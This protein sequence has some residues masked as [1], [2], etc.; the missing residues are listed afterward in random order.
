VVYDTNHWDALDNPDVARIVTT[1]ASKIAGKLECIH[2]AD[3]L[4]M[5]TAEAI[6][7]GRFGDVL[8]RV[9]TDPGLLYAEIKGYLQN[10]VRTEHKH[11]IENE[12]YEVRFLEGAYE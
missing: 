2:D 9:K 6:G 1:L 8:E 3:D 11:Y 7:S 5:Q 12:S 10:F 4:W